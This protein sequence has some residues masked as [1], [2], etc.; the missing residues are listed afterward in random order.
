MLTNGAQMQTKKDYYALQAEIDA[1]GEKHGL[2]CGL[3][4]PCVDMQ[5]V[6]DGTGVKETDSDF[7]S[8]MVSSMCSAAGGRAEEKGIDI[9]K[10]L[11]RTIY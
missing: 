1:V 5:N 9:N 11:G 2:G 4:D 3:T 8:R 6:L 7:W 10:E